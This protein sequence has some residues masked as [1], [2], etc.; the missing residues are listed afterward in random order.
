MEG[1]VGGMH[2]YFAFLDYKKD[3]KFGLSAEGKMSITFA[4]VKNDHACL[5]SSATSTFF[6]LKPPSRYSFKFIQHGSQR[7]RLLLLRIYECLHKL[8]LLFLG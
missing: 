7:L 3:L 6:D 8:L 2:K 4:L 5:Y 1:I